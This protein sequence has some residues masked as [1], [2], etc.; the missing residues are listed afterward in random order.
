MTGITT[1]KEGSDNS[2]KNWYKKLKEGK[3]LLSK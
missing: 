3:P 1:S 2:G